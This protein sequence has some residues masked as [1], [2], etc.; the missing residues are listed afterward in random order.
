MR[1]LESESEFS[2]GRDESKCME[3]EVVSHSTEFV[4]SIGLPGSC[5]FGSGAGIVTDARRESRM[6]S[7]ASSLVCVDT[8]DMRV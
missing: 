8:W 3:D 4:E 6:M 2:V 1:K 5:P 7:E